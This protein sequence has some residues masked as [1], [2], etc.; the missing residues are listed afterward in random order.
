MF[1][2]HARSRAQARRRKR[3][4]TRT[5]V[6]QRARSWLWT[7]TRIFAAIVLMQ[8][9]S[10]VVAHFGSPAVSSSFDLKTVVSL[11]FGGAASSVLVTAPIRAFADANAARW[12]RIAR[13]LDEPAHPEGHYSQRVFLQE[14]KN[15]DKF[16]KR[17]DDVPGEGEIL[18][19]LKQAPPTKRSQTD[20]V[21]HL[22]NMQEQIEMLQAQRPKDARRFR[23]VCFVTHD[24]ECVAYQSFDSFR[25]A[26]LFGKKQEYEK[27]LNT[28]DRDKYV[29]RLQN[30]QGDDAVKIAGLNY[31]DI[32][33]EL[34]FYCVHEPLTKR[35]ALVVLSICSRREHLM[36]VDA[37]SK[38][39][40]V[41]TPRELLTDVL[42]DDGT[43]SK[44]EQQ[45]ICRAY[46][47]EKA[48]VALPK[49][50]DV[51][52][53]SPEPDQHEDQAAA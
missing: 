14:D 1:S 26:L 41:V 33:P 25:L 29:K 21:Y 16:I 40:G 38:P 23:W 47:L 15:K 39:V 32:L 31:A 17:I 2:P 51:K 30:H 7:A 45:A 27:I 9:L 11:L 20:S 46:P 53:P 6:W 18:L 12:Q 24:G 48:R 43:I 37:K 4:D 44:E 13:K 36:L 10:V 28:S 3:R 35:E 49:P 50:D 52:S 8:S 34:E 42:L 19:L 22:A 5:R